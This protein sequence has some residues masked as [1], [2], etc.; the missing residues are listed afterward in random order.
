MALEQELMEAEAKQEE[1]KAEAAEKKN[2]DDLT[3]EEIE[4]V[5]ELEQS[6]WWR[7]L[8][9]CMKKRIEKQ[10]KDIIVL[11]KDNF[12]NPKPDWFT[13][14]EVIGALLAGMW[15]MERL[16]NVLVADPEETR[17]AQEEMRKLEAQ[18]RWEQ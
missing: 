5:K 16:V 3:D 9:E 2:F 7:I 1:N 17:K 12:M 8:K 10:E 18:M 11:A 6:E 14:Y 13:Y 4:A 15:E